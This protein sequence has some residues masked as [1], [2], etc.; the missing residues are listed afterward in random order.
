MCILATAPATTATTPTAAAAAATTT[1]T[2]AGHGTT[3]T[4][5]GP[6]V[7]VARANAIGSACR[8]K[9]DKACRRTHPET[10][11]EAA[12]AVIIVAGALRSRVLVRVSWA[13]PSV[14]AGD[15]DLLRR[16]GR[17]RRKRIG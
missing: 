14:R 17:L 8:G 2:T 7:I 9:Q 6:I 15:K 12:A 13:R 4:N 1:A 5:A 16:V 11:R 3:T 10:H